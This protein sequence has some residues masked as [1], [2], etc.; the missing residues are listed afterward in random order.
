M[1]MITDIANI[2]SSRQAAAV[3]NEWLVSYVGDRFIAGDPLLDSEA[4]V[5][6]VPILFL[7]AQQGPIGVAGEALV[8]ALAGEV[9]SRPAISELKRQALKL[10]EEKCGISD[11]SIPNSRN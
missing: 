9:C 4:D 3:V 11:S 5:W 8:D 6:R 2:I 7:Y 10:Y 1:L